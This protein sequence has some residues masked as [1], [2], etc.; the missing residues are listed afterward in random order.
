MA[1]GYEEPHALLDAI[2]DARDL[3]ND[4]QLARFLDFMPGVISK[5]RNRR[6]IVSEEFRMRVMRRTGWSLEKIDKLAPP[7]KD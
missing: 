2:L 6:V 3:K 5:V 1:K 7:A 4:A